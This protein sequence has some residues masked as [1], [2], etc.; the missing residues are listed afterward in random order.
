MAWWVSHILGLVLAIGLALV[1][2]SPFSLKQSM[3]RVLE[4]FEAPPRDDE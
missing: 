1:S 2:I 4:N 3:D